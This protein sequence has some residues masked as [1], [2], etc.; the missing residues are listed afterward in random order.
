MQIESSSTSLSVVTASTT[1]DN[2]G[3]IFG[4]CIPVGILVIAAIGLLSY[5]IHMRRESFTV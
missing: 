2:I 5:K 1:T 4:I 3:L